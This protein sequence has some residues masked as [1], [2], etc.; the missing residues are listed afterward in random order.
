MRG[1][2]VEARL[3]SEIMDAPAYT[4]IR[5]KRKRVNELNEDNSNLDR[6]VNTPNKRL[7]HIGSFAQAKSEEELKASKILL[8]TVGL[9]GDG[10]KKIKINDFS[11]KQ[12][13]K[14]VQ[15]LNSTE[16][17]FEGKG[18]KNDDQNAINN[19]IDDLKDEK[20]VES[21]VSSDVDDFDDD[22]VDAMARQV[23]G[24]LLLELILN[25]V[26]FGSPSRIQSSNHKW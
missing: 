7:R 18:A 16:D 2:F 4:I 14:Y 17:R 11:S 22:F 19:N 9:Q 24:K 15:N 21:D 10:L 25:S 6:Y 13:V 1:D 26:Q 23:N 8:Q 20:E 3:Q 12:F 5:V